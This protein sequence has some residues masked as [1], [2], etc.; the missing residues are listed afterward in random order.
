VNRLPLKGRRYFLDKINKGVYWS[1][2]WKTILIF[3]IIFLLVFS[4]IF[5]W[6]FRASTEIA[7][8]QLH[9]YLLNVGRLNCHRA[10]A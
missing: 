9:D 6:I 5:Y 1:I 2:R 8:E 3:T 4:G 10:I 7:T